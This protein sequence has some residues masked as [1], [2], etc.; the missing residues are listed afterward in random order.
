MRYHTQNLNERGNKVVGSM[1][2]RGR[3][4]LYL[5]EKGKRPNERT[6][7]CE[8]YLGKHA[9]DF[10]ATVSFGTGDD[11]AGLLFHLGIPWLFSIYLGMDRFYSCKECSFGMAIHNTAIWFYPLTWRMESATKKDPWYRHHYS[12]AFP[13]DWDWYS[14][15]ML[16]CREHIA[17]AA[18]VVWSE[19]RKNRK[20]FL[21]GYDEQ[22]RIEASICEEHNYTYVRKNG[23]VQHR[24]A[25]LHIKRRTWRMR[26]WPL[27]PFKK[28]STCIEVSFNEEIGE[29]VESW[30]GGTTG[31]GYTLLPLETPLECLRRMESE[32]KFGR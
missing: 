32:R 29:G 31:C 8:W 12:W 17:E 16:D 27:L 19:T 15:E 2:W 20:R 7:H 22:K 23:Q 1:L 3:G 6:I 25:I 9:R 14:T 21:D 11:D 26:W 5:G 30:K 28:V 13:W 4:W 24:K 10:S 18:P